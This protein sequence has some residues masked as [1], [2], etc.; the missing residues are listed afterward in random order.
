M[1]DIEKKRNSFSDFV[2]RIEE[3]IS[4]LTTL[5]I[6]TIVG[7]FHYIDNE[8]IEAKR[9]GEFR[10]IFTDMS[11]IDG[12]ITTRISNDIMQDKYAWVRDFHA[13]KE[14]KGHEIVQGNIRAIVQLFE[15]F[16]SSKNVKVNEENIDE[17]AAEPLA[18]DDGFVK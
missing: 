15:L 5:N 16:R 12:D 11:L 18:D 14:E 13:R 2:N 8:T 10:M 4:D 6:R 9:D 3:K 7:D 1:A 17:T